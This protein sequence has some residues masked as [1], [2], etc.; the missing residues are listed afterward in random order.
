LQETRCLL[1]PFPAETQFEDAEKLMN[2]LLSKQLRHTTPRTIQQ[3]SPLRQRE[4]RDSA[5]EVLVE[6]HWVRIVT[7]DNQTVIEVN[8]NVFL[9]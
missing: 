5:L 2:W 3:S 4:R 1:A 6:H 8:P 7:R 9:S